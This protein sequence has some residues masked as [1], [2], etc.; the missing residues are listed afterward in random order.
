MASDF[1]ANLAYV[2]DYH[3]RHGSMPP[4][5]EWWLGCHQKRISY[6]VMG[7]KHMVAVR[8]A[9]GPVGASITGGWKGCLGQCPRRPGAPLGLAHSSCAPAN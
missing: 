1:E 5:R 4:D 8:A 6:G 9:S 2:D 3:K 7:G